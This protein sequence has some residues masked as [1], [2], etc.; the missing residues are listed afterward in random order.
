MNYNQPY[1]Y[2]A[3]PTQMSGAQNDIQ[4]VRWVSNSNEV[5]SIPVPDGIKMMFM[6]RE[7]PIFYIKQGSSV[8]A[9][10]FEKIEPPKPEDFVTRTEFDELRRKYESLVQSAS[11]NAVGQQPVTT[12]TVQSNAIATGCT[13]LQGNSATSKGAVM[14]T[15][16]PAG[17]E[18][19]T[20]QPVS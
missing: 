6:E 14:P 20:A 3:Y 12:A 11:T 4:G 13:E 7:N 10:K 18:Q 17:M 15:N 2:P 16:I 1:G 8:D 9:F 5:N 19:A